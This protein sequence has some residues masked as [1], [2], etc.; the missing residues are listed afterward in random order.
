MT[1]PNKPIL[2]AW[3]SNSFI[4]LSVKMALEGLRFQTPQYLHPLLH[5]SVA[6]QT[7]NSGLGMTLKFV[8]RVIFRLNRL[9]IAFP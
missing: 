8:Q 9:N 1:R 5:L 2:V 7:I 4:S 6:S 3:D